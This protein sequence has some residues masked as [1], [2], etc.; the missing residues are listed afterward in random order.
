MTARPA[1]PEENNP[2][3]PSPRVLI[4]LGSIIVHYEEMNSPTGHHFDKHA[5]DSAYAT[6]GVKEWFDQMRKAAFLPVKR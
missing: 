2:L 3:K 4:A 1:P 5:L 6:P